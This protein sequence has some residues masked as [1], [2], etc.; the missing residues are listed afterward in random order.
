MYNSPEFLIYFSLLCFVILLASV[1]SCVLRFWALADI[2][3]RGLGLDI[4][5]LVFWP[6]P[7]NLGCNLLLIQYLLSRFMCMYSTS[8]FLLL[9][10][11]AVWSVVSCLSRENTK[12]CRPWNVKLIDLCFLIFAPGGPT[13][14]QFTVFFAHNTLDWTNRLINKPELGSLGMLE[15]GKCLTMQDTIYLD[16]ISNPKLFLL[17]PSKSRIDKSSITVLR[18]RWVICSP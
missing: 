16:L 12:L 4:P 2:F 11:S 7:C 5:L 9:N 8:N 1:S 17:F 18:T 13:P 10:V 14:V 15:Q 3:F 6:L